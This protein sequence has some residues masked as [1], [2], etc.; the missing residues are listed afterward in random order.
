MGLPP[1]HIASQRDEDSSSDTT[2]QEAPAAAPQS[3]AT[4]F[5]ATLA[6][7]NQFDS[8]DEQR[9]KDEY[10]TTRRKYM[11]IHH[12]RVQREKLVMQLSLEKEKSKQEDNEEY[13]VFVRKQ[14]EK[15]EKEERQKEEQERELDEK[16]CDR[17]AEFGFE[18][19]QMEALVN[20]DQDKQKEWQMESA[21]TSFD[22]VFATDKQSSLSGEQQRQQP[23]VMSD[24]DELARTTREEELHKRFLGKQKDSQVARAED[25]TAPSPTYVKVHRQ[26]LDIETLHY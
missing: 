16:M 7:D 1:R 9:E 2:L 8:S 25:P 10:E 24:K 13:E 23:L 14:I 20:P 3:S 18:D 11:E 22:A 17:L 5:D 6:T 15:Q 19:D 4:S 21:T 26:H 12:E